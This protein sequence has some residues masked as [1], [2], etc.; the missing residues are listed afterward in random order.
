ME[1]LSLDLIFAFTLWEEKLIF[2][3]KSKQNQI[4]K[5]QREWKAHANYTYSKLV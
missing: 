2:F 5:I 3:N 1:F 4:K